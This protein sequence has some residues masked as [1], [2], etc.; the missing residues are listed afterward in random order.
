MKPLKIFR[1]EF[2]YQV[3]RISTWL[4]LAVLLLFAILM[5]LVITPGDG[6]YPNNI[7]HIT[8]ITIIG[9]LIWMVMDVS[10]AGEAVARDVQT[11]M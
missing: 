1:F 6:V 7:L 10:I 8:G 4:Y 5:N 11:R 9:G 3:R 2:S